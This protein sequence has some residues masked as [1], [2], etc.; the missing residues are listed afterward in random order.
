M[1][2]GMLWGNRILVE[3]TVVLSLM[4]LVLLLLLI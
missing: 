2:L 4:L 1:R 3:L